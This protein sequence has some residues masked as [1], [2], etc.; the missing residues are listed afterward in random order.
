MVRGVC[1]GKQNMGLIEKFLQL[2]DEDAG[3]KP[4]WAQC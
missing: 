2:V 1:D 3:P 4:M